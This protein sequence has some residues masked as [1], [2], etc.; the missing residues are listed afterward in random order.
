LL[1]T[2]LQTWPRACLQACLQTWLLAGLALAGCSQASSAQSG[3]DTVAR[4]R[5]CLKYESAAREACFDTL[6][7]E[8]TREASLNAPPPVRK[9]EDWIISST[10]SPVDYSPQITAT[11]ITRKTSGN[12]PSL[13]T[14]GCRFQRT[15]ISLGTVA[16]WKPLRGDDVRVAYRLNS[17]P[18]VLERWAT[19]AGG[20]SAA[21]RGDA[22][23]LLDLMSD[24]SQFGVRVQDGSGPTPPATFDL[25]GVEAVRKRIDTACKSPPPKSG[26]SI[27]WR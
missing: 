24:P 26:N 4:I 20:H 17:Q 22:A 7:R 25:A 21:L 5:A 23:R 2:W 8:L 6:W 16:E 10:M 3:E 15:E 12:A 19:S 18:E 9:N 11:K 14:I 27:E 13:L 1:R